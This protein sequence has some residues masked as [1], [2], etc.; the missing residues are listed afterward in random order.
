MLFIHFLTKIHYLIK[1]SNENLWGN[2]CLIAINNI[3]MQKFLMVLKIGLIFG[4]QIFDFV[5]EVKCDLDMFS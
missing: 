2:M 5:L 4:M 1:S 3:T